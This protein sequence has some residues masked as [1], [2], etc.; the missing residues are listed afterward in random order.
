M[1]ELDE[2]MK[3][4]LAGGVAVQVGTASNAGKPQAA[5][6]WGPRVNPNGTVTVFLDTDAS[7]PTLANL[8][9]NG[10]IAV[11]FADPITYRSIQF[12]GKWLTSAVPT[13]DERA[14][15]RRHRDL[16]ASTTVLV[17]DNPE[18]MRNRWLQDT[19]RIDFSVERAFDQTPGPNAGREL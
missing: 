11:I 6:A 9:M 1:F 14:W 17:G 5:N 12:K 16:F 18:A 7:G 10:R 3:D 13:E 19:T 4:F 2:A 8:A 15:V